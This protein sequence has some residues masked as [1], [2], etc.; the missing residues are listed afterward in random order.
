MTTTPLWSSI[1]TALRGEISAGQYRPGDR[2]PTEAALARRFGVNR[3]TV[4]HALSGLVEDGMITTRRGAGAFVTRLPTEYPL[5]RRVRFHQN[6]AAA[7]R[8]PQRV[9]LH[10]ETRNADPAETEALNLGPDDKVHSAEGVSL[11]DGLPIAHFRSVY[12][13]TR[14][15]DLLAHLQTHG[16]VT[17]ALAACGVPDYTR[18]S[19]RLSARRASM[20]E[21]QHLMLREGDPVLL[22]IGINVDPDGRPVEYGQTC[23]AGDHVTL[24]ITND[25]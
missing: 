8:L 13:A 7:G 4:R 21:A 5:G 3:H 11:A 25:A 6:L 16:S 22:S 24:S 14:F 19:T 18:A 2:L 15:P 9:F 10:L 17:Q 23:F 1:A 20:I 12:P